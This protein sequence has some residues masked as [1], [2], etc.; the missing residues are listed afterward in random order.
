[1]TYFTA[2]IYLR[3]IWFGD[4]S[5]SGEQDTQLTRGSVYLGSLSAADVLHAGIRRKMEPLNP[6]TDAETVFFQDFGV[7]LVFRYLKKFMLLAYIEVDFKEKKKHL[8]LI[9]LARGAIDLILTASSVNMIINS[10][11]CEELTAVTCC[12][13][14]K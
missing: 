14:C 2:V 11:L 5:D 13:D 12:K 6:Q 10:E 3:Q 7:Y 8:K 4:F 1:M 9:Q